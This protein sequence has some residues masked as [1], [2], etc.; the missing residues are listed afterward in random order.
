M[1]RHLL[2][3]RSILF[4]CSVLICLQALSFCPLV[5]PSGET[6][7]DGNP[8]K[9][10]IGLTDPHVFIHNN[11]AYMFATHDFSFTNTGFTMKDWWVWSS[12]DLV[13]WYQLCKIT[14]EET[15]LKRPFN[16]CWAPF[17]VMRNG[18]CY[19]YFSAGKTEVGVIVGDTPSGPWHDPLGKPLI[20]KGL[21]PT[22]Q[23]DP[24]VM[25]DDDGNAYMVYGTFNYFIVRLNPDMISLAETPRPVVIDHPTGPYGEGK[26]DDKPSLHKYNGRYYLSWSGFY[27]VSDNVYGPYVYKG[28]LF[29]E[30]NI[31][32]KFRKG[33]ISF[34]RHGNFFQLHG[35]C[36]YTFND[37]S[38]SECTHYYR[39][40]CMVYVHYLDNGDIAPVHLNSIGVGQ[41]DVAV[42]CIEAENYFRISEC[43]K[44]ECPEGG[45]E[46]QEIRKGSFLNYP[47][48]HNLP[49]K[50]VACFRVA[51]GSGRTATIEIRRR[52]K[53][54]QLLGRCE[55]AD[56]GG[57]KSYQTV[58]CDFNTVT[59]ID[60][61]CLVFK[62]R[63]EKL[64]HLNWFR[65][66][67]K[68]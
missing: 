37:Q 14:P 65:I 56:T 35:Q 36:Y 12:D 58:S 47:N 24:D 9:R 49:L 27:A 54:G 8:L 19:F 46:I 20:A 66:E 63:G 62:G 41:Y 64:L 23:R 33:R 50:G 57:W 4:A 43:V 60:E 42:G 52:N 2:S 21:T 45:F 68:L 7:E 10:G 67:A 29:K 53:K 16:S 32:P 3:I 59:D 5:I 38:S 39:D 51:N 22:E 28:C 34:D 26:M 6:M 48:V 40:A 55:V 44:K 13:N 17:G 25:I 30:E 11:R 15:F 31:E 1:K 18:K 61:L